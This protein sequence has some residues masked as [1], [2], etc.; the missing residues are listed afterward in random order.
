[1]EMKIAP[2]PAEFLER[3]R[4][5]GIDDQGQP[6]ERMLAEGGEPCRDVLR[7]ARAGESLILASFSPFDRANPYK[8]FGPVFV[9]AEPDGTEP[10]QNVLPTNGET[11]YL[12]ERFVLRAYSSGQTIV[13][14]ELV[15]AARGE[16]T[17][18]RLLERTDVAWVDA[19][20][21]A[22]GCF[23]LRITRAGAVTASA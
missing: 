1:M 7:R 17:A 3:V 9:L 10:V 4:T 8:E 16:E 11:P 15:D 2:M 5:T 12:R 13:D 21:P 6:V 22:Y 19:R 18:R 14:A 23:A 20:F